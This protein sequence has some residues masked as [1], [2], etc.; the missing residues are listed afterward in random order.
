MIKC[1]KYL[2][3]A[4]TKPSQLLSM[5]NYLVNELGHWGFGTETLGYRRVLGGSM[6]GRP[7]GPSLAHVGCGP[8]PVVGAQPG[9]ALCSC[10]DALCCGPD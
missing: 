3:I 2:Y 4:Q 6:A 1:V 5:M 9:G 10:G 8:P 7:P